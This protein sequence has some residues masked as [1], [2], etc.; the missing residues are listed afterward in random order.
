[1]L[2]GTSYKQVAASLEIISEHGFDRGTIPFAEKSI[3][4]VRSLSTVKS[5]LNT[6]MREV[7]GIHMGPRSPFE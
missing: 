7:D 1:M 6:A 4:P 3:L 5:H 2:L